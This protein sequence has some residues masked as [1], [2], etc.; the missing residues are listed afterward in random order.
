MTIRVE[1]TEARRGD[2]RP[3][4]VRAADDRIAKWGVLVKS[5][6]ADADVRVCVW[7]RVEVVGLG[8]DR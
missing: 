2:S 1:A 6:S 3:V 5:P 8:W 4:D 7:R